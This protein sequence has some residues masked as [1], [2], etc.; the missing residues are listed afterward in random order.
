MNGEPRSKFK[1][2][3]MA[4]FVFFFL[5]QGDE[6]HPNDGMTVTHLK[7][8]TS[9]SVMIGKPSCLQA[10]ILKSVVTIMTVLGF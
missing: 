8:L 9:V 1:G 3:L 7:T 2:I 6:R 5:V 10:W 4:K